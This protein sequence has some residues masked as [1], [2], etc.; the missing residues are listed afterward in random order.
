MNL[1]RQLDS[2]YL[3]KGHIEALLD[4]IWTSRV[5]Q[6]PVRKVENRAL[7]Q[8]RVLKVELAHLFKA[9]RGPF[10]LAWTTLSAVTLEQD[11]STS[12]KAPAT[13]KRLI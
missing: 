6:D 2:C 12:R 8:M 10:A 3:L 13:E 7:V 9:F 1:R 11:T 5:L 4:L